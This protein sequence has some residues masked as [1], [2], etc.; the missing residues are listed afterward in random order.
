MREEEVL[1]FTALPDFLVDMANGAC[2]VFLAKIDDQVERLEHL[3]SL[4]PGD[5]LAWTPPIPRAF[6]VSVLLGHVLD[7]L[8]G[9]CAVLYAANP[10]KLARLLELKKLPANQSLDPAVTAR[11]LAAYRAGIHEGFV[12]LNDTDLERRLPTVFVPEGEPLMALL[13]INYEHLASHKYQLF[14]YLRMLG[15]EVASRDLYHFSGQSK[16]P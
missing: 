4:V 6:T 7:C 2:G 12:P 11:H 3:V 5:K 15:L 9:F 13:L 10:E 14:L 16:T 8:A 1:S